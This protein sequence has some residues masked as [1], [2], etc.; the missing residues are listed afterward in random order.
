MLSLSF[1]FKSFSIVIFDSSAVI[2]VTVLAGR[3]PTLA[4]GWILNLARIRE[5]CW[6]P[7]P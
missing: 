3:E 1:L 5:E 4:V 7:T 6:W 2:A